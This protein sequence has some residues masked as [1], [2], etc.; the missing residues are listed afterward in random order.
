MTTE[1]LQNSGTTSTTPSATTKTV[2]PVSSNVAASNSEAPSSAIGE[3]QDAFGPILLARNKVDASTLWANTTT[4]RSARIL[5]LAK[6]PP[7]LPKWTG[8]FTL[9]SFPRELRDKIYFHYIY[10]PKGIVYVSCWFM[11]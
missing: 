4:Q 5:E 8:S 9:L 6:K 3:L 2:G 1:A 7:I 10:R 11:V